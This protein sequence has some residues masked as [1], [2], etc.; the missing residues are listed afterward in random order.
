LLRS[1]R[2]RRRSSSVA[3]LVRQ[4]DEGGGVG[5]AV[6]RGGLVGGLA[7]VSATQPRTAPPHGMTASVRWP[8]FLTGS[9]GPEYL[10][11]RPCLAASTLFLASATIAAAE[12]PL[13]DDELLLL[14][15]PLDPLL[16]LLPQPAAARR[17]RHRSLCDPSSC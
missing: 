7:Q 9:V 6:A 11:G 2:A 3:H 12:P 1:G 8:E 14:L 4:L 17:P 5:E 16:S 15:D 10:A 13:D